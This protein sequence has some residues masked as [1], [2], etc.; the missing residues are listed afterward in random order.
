MSTIA[1]ARTD[2]H[3]TRPA[4]PSVATC[5]TCGAPIHTRQATHTGPR[6]RVLIDPHRPVDV[7]F[8]AHALEFRRHAE[9]FAGDADKVRQ[10]LA[11]AADC[12]RLAAAWR[13]VETQLAALERAA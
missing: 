6:Y 2:A 10:L 1:P 8:E 13:D 7:Q 9:S 11:A 3:S 4:D 12:E 5:R